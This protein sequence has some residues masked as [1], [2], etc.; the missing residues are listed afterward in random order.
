[1]RSRTTSR[2]IRMTQRNPTSLKKQ[3][4][5]TMANWRKR[6]M[7]RCSRSTGSNVTSCCLKRLTKQTTIQTNRWK[8]TIATK[9]TRPSLLKKA[10]TRN[11][12]C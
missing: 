5:Q 4:S 2:T 9:R 8:P 3:N 1:M 6:P 12:G 7:I 10:K 11:F